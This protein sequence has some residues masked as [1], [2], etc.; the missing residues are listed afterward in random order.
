MVF[1]PAGFRVLWPIMYLLPS[2]K[3]LTQLQTNCIEDWEQKVDAIV[4]ETFNE[5][6]RLISG[7]P[8]L[9]PDVFRQ[10]FGKAGGKKVKDIFPNF[11]FT[12]TAA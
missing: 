6:M 2:K 8:A 11:K 9:V 7:H 10:A 4:E 3:P 1:Q 5:D 12:C